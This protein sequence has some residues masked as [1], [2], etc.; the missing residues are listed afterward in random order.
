MAAD[1]G[2][3]LRL[4]LELAERQRQEAGPVLPQAVNLDNFHIRQEGQKALRRAWQEAEGV[5]SA[6]EEADRA[7]ARS[8]RRGEDQRRVVHT[9]TAAWTQAERAFG[10]AADH[11]RAWQRAAAAL[12]LFRPDGQLN[13]RTWAAAELQAAAAALTGTRGAKA[14][15][16]LLDPRALTFL[17]RL[18]DDLAA[19]E[20]RADVRQALAQWWRLRRRPPAGQAPVSAAGVLAEPLQGLICRGLASDFREAYGRVARVLGRVVRASSVVECMNSVVRMHQARH[21]NL[22]Q[23]LLDLKRLHYNCRGFAAGKRKGHC[24]Y[25]HL[26]LRLPTYDWWE[27]LNKDPQ[28]LEQELSNPRLAA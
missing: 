16:M 22:T 3:G 15:R 14:R 6:A 5:W 21:R 1:G 4:G 11:E 20:P 25:H 26:G 24:P 12:E 18:H 13:D 28:E 7:V 19:A 9:A 27:L 8:R 17:D 23:A 2:S 10:V